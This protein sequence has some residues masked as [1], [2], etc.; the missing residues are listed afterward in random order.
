MAT[1]FC[2]DC[3]KEMARSAQSCPHCGARNRW[4]T[5]KEMSPLLIVGVVFLPLVFSW[6]TL[7]NGY[8]TKARVWSFAWLFVAM[9]V[10][11]GTKDTPVDEEREMKTAATGVKEKP[12]PVEIPIKVTSKAIVSAYEANE[13]QAD[14][15]YRGKMVE[16]RGRIGEIK[17]DVFNNLYVTLDTE[18]PYEIRE[19]QAFFDDTMSETLAALKKGEHLSVICKVEGL[20]MNVIVKKC[21][22]K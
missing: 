19:V 5:Q 13:V 15:L 10:A 4:S 9:L 17:K 11:F 16:V 6:F 14:N 18:D 8:S 21:K 7:A 2:P 3:N 20:M 12:K 1:L 22:I